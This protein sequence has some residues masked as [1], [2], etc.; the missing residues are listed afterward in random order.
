MAISFSKG[1]LLALDWDKKTLR[2]VLVRPRADGVDLLRAVSV[3][4][5]AD[6]RIDDPAEFGGFVRE[7]ISRTHAGAKR[8]VVAIPR[9]HV[10]L[11]NL[12]LPPTTPEEMP[13]LVQFQVTK[14]LPFSPDQAAVDF[15]V[16]GEFD[17][18]APSSVLVSAVRIEVL[19][20][21]RSV[22]E[23]AELTVERIG[24]RPFAN[25]IAVSAGAPDLAQK[26]FLIIEIGPQFTEIDIIRNGQIL[27]S[28]S[29]LVS[30]PDDKNLTSEAVTDSRIVTVKLHEREDDFANRQLVNDLMVE[31]VRSVEAYRATDPA[32]S[33]DQIMV[34][35]AS[36]LE[37]FLVQTLA[38]RFATP[39]ELYTPD[40][41]MQLTHDRAREL[42]GFNAALGLA[43]GHARKGLSTIDFLHP[44]KSVSRRAMR[45]RKMPVAVATAVLFLGSAVTLYFQYVQP[46]LDKAKQL[47]G[48][49]ARLKK[50]EEPILAF[51][52][53]VE[54]LESWAESEQ[55]WPQVLASVTEVF[56]PEKEGYAVRLD[57]EEN[58]APRTALRETS[59]RMRFRTVNLGTVNALASAMRKNGF[60]SVIPGKET[61]SDAK[62]G[63]KFDTNID[64]IVPVRHLEETEKTPA[65]RKPSPVE[66]KPEKKP[67][68]TIPAETK[69]P[70][71]VKPVDSKG[72]PPAGP[73][74]RRAAP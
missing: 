63:Y 5:P 1:K 31:I 74:S 33:L 58:I 21:Y 62:D 20:F 15:V 40:R 53:Q 49:R 38:A 42:G 73:T 29:A 57:L 60:L 68:E 26:T 22:A 37:A 44:K 24:L 23:S 48:Q 19:N 71:G 9:D 66:S 43:I 51:K 67:S 52:S 18:R 41:A 45:M 36:G 61:P 70:E 39:A 12:S 2:M 7:A 3:A 64:A 32:L 46:K 14:E 28:R 35:G 56:P 55:H 4:I 17:P 69:P 47:D 10:V 30:L 13:A 16:N 8:A 65:E 59:L 25:L 34:C 54:A 6:V 11:H 27:F 50:Q 72:Q